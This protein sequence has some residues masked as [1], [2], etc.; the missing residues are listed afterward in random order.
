MAATKLLGDGLVDEAADEE[1]TEEEEGSMVVE[2]GEE[3]VGYRS[4]RE[5]CERLVAGG[6]LDSRWQVVISTR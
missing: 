1:A 6:V 2:R 5:L 4:R 3:E